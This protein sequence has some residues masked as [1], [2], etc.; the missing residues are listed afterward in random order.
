MTDP[1]DP[2][3][4]EYLRSLNL[5]E[6]LALERDR[7]DDVDLLI[8]IGGAFIKLRQLDKCIEYYVRALKIDPFNGWTHLYF[9]SLGYGLKCYDEAIKHFEYAADFLPDSAYP[10]WYL[11]DTYRVK[12]NFARADFHYQKAVENDPAD[13]KARQKLEDWLHAKQGGRD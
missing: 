13:L 9:G 10:Q 2:E 7:P 5:T 6:L 4:L 3:Y 12:G 1:E 11:G 8:R